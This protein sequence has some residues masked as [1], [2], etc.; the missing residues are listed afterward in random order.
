MPP[1]N[2]LF[3]CFS[4]EKLKYLD[5]F[6]LTDSGYFIPPDLVQEHKLE[7]W[8]NIFETPDEEVLISG[9]AVLNYNKKKASWAWKVIYIDDIDSPLIH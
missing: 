8:R 1:S 7:E 2:K 9:K 3:R 4:S 6:A 5:E